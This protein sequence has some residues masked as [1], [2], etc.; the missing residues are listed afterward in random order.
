[1]RRALDRIRHLGNRTSMTPV[2]SRLLPFI[3]ALS[4]GFP[5]LFPAPVAAFYQ[6]PEDILNADNAPRENIHRVDGSVMSEDGPATNVEVLVE[7]TDMRVRRQIDT[8]RTRT[9]ENG[10]SPIDLS[11][12]E[13]PE[14]GLRPP[15]DSSRR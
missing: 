10:E 11:K 1:M 13:A 14:L 4:A 12:F 5:L 9:D 2:R 3:F 7:I 15:R 8:L 6:I